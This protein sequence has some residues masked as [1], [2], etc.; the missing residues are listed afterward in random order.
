M[1]SSTYFIYH[2]RPTKGW[3]ALFPHGAMTVSSKVFQAP[4]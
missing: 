3:L 1:E 2:D 4:I